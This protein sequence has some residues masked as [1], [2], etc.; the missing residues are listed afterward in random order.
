MRDTN[1]GIPRTIEQ[2]EGE[3]KGV[4]GPVRPPTPPAG[5]FSVC[6][7]AA[8]LRS[9]SVSCSGGW[10]FVGGVG[11]GGW[12]GFLAWEEGGWL[13]LVFYV[14]IIGVL[15]GAARAGLR[16]VVSLEGAGVMSIS[17]FWSRVLLSLRWR[18]WRRQVVGTVPGGG[19][20]GEGHAQVRT[21]TSDESRDLYVRSE[22]VSLILH[23]LGEGD[24]VI[25][26]SQSA[27][28]RRFLV[29]DPRVALTLVKLAM[30]DFIGWGPDGSA[31]VQ[32]RF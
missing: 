26:V 16:S 19:G 28:G 8:P 24:E 18:P 25:G 5:G 30:A 13:T 14:S 31:Q 1:W 3:K 11:L 17:R 7:A 4:G 15:A 12:L 23:T 22:G 10:W 20:L 32:L 9:R 29:P 6:A 21:R 27:V 2:T